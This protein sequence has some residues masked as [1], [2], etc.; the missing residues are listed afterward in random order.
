M[1]QENEIKDSN[2][3]IIYNLKTRKKFFSKMT[4]EE[5]NIWLKNLN[6]DENILNE[7]K[8]I[9]KNGQDLISIYNNNQLIEKINLDLH[10][11][12]IINSAIEE[13]LEE[14]LKINIEIEKD[15]NIILN[16]ENEP[17]YE[18]KEIYAYLEL[19]LKKK[20][21]LC[22]KNNPN[23]LLN[24]N[25]LIYKKILLNPD[26]YCNLSFFNENIFTKNN[27]EKNNL[28]NN[29]NKNDMNMNINMNQTPDLNIDKKELLN[30]GGYNS[31]FQ[32][33]KKNPISDFTTEYQMPNFNKSNDINM[34]NNINNN[35]DFKYQNI[36][37]NKDKDKDINNKL[38][39]NL[40]NNNI[41]INNLNNL[42]NNNSN[43]EPP[44]NKFS[45]TFN[46]INNT[47]SNLNKNYFTQRN[48]N[49]KNFSQTQNELNDNGEIFSKITNF[50][51]IDRTKSV[52]NNNNI[53]KEKENKLDNINNKNKTENRYEFVK[54]QE[55]DIFKNKNMFN[56]N[57]KPSQ[58]MQQNPVN[59]INNLILKTQTTNIPQMKNIKDDSDDILKSLREKY[60]L[61]NNNNN[62]EENRE[63]K[64]SKMDF[65]NDYKPKTP[66]AEGRRTF[67]NDNM[68]FNFMEENTNDPLENKFLNINRQNKKEEFDKFNF[69]NKNMNNQYINN[70]NEI[71]EQNK[72]YINIGKIRPNRPSPG[73]D[74]N[75]FQ[76]KASEYKNSFGQNMDGNE[77]GD[78]LI[79]E[80]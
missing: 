65:K 25:T 70:N 18:L 60:S 15:K 79:E 64:E 78:E 36:L 41:N 63:Y 67:N 52:N 43:K 69:L 56:N 80:N 76:Y 50:K 66:I 22:P 11:K 7:L 33:K 1:M 14:Q 35:K 23:E 24:P 53:E 10:S 74:F 38:N 61:Q 55:L 45:N 20:V 30:K 49:P 75:N 32:I 39:I 51:I 6:L 13:S 57:P 58:E 44:K 26:K 4:E 29:I 71:D 12:N 5:T 2:D 28:N 77:G 46:I 8:N 59:D 27:E 31:L 48:F 9:V 73:L 21:F 72:A 54:Y 3:N 42:N 16:I 40:E 19:L 17:K 47:D 68:K 37:S 34:N 62:I